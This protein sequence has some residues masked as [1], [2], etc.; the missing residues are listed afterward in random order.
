MSMWPHATLEVTV[1][2]GRAFIL[3]RHEP[4]TLLTDRDSLT[5][6]LPAEA[7]NE[8]IYDTEALK[9]FRQAHPEYRDVPDLEL[10]RRIR[11]MPEVNRQWHVTKGEILWSEPTIVGVKVIQGPR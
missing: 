7:A 1:K 4:K 9:L 3:D 2:D 6:A 11:A 10:A 8:V 5:R